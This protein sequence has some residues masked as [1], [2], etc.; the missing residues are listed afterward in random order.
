MASAA[1]NIKRKTGDKAAG[2]GVQVPLD[3]QTVLAAVEQL[4]N[5]VNEL[6]A[7]HNTLVTEFGAHTHGGVTVGAGTTAAP[8]ASAAA[9]T[10][11]P[12]AATN[13]FTDA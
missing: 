10:G 2:G 6:I 8:A 7:R 5:S 12:V 11:T 9:V 3:T 13:L 4:Q 1:K